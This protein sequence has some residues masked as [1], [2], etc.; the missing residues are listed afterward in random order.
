M[1]MMT[2]SLTSALAL[3]QLTYGG[4]TGRW[5]HEAMRSHATPRL[6]HIT[7]GQG[8]ITIAGLTG[9]YGP[10]NLIYIPPH[11]MYGME[12]GTTVYAQILTLPAQPDEWPDTAFHLRLMDVVTQ[13]EL[14][15]LIEAIE[16]EL[17]PNGDA[18]AALCHLGLLTIFV[19]RHL[20]SYKIDDRRNS[21]PA[22]LVARYTALIARGFSQDKSVADYAAELDVTPTHL[23][24]CCKQTCDRSALVLLNDRI[25]YEACKLLRDTQT[26]V[27]DVAKS[28]G[29][30]SAAYF[31]RSFQDKSGKTPSDFRRA[32]GTGYA[33]GTPL[34]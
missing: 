24:R 33:R 22:K 12:L 20:G 21:A 5:R 14:Q 16:R 13:K 26:P 3:A 25:H 7:K 8:R 34:A 6:I 28:L 10:N 27:Q 4:P 30:H 19:E 9:G 29:F 31:T 15:Q 1:S 18:R 2:P 11:T 17:Q 23:T 32:I